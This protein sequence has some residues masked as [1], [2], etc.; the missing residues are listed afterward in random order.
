M[1]GQEALVTPEYTLVPPVYS[2]ST[3]V[4]RGTTRVYSGATRVL[5]SPKLSFVAVDLIFDG[6]LKKSIKV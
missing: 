2:G 1:G 4:C 6:P 3:R 5:L